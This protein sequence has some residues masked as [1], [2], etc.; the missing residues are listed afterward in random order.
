MR[1]WLVLLP[2]LL[3]GGC[4]LDL[5]NDFCGGD[6]C[7]CETDGDCGEGARCVN[8]F[9][10]T[11]GACGDETVTPPEECDN[12]AANGPSAPCTPACRLNRCGD[13]Y[14][15]TTSEPCDDGNDTN[16]DGCDTNCTLSACGNGVQAPGEACDDG[17]LTNGDGCDANCTLT[18][19]ASQ[20]GCFALDN[21]C[22]DGVC[23][24]TTG[25]CEV[26][27][28]NEGG[29]C[30]GGDLC[31][32]GGTCN[33]GAC[34]GAVATDCSSLSTDCV[35]GVCDPD[36][37]ACVAENVNDGGTC[38][39]GN[40]CTTGSTCLAGVCGGGVPATCDD[41]NACTSDS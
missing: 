14:Q 27:P 18:Q 38:D 34:V 15:L 6:P 19:C 10:D 24:P 8:N 23:N 35:Q 30:N 12:G 16:G 29:V 41:D 22:A 20:G 21:D 7:Q 31:Q 11:F 28:L 26:V 39:D 17:N 37:V 4:T 9:C 36:T 40:P 32:G 3:V 13:G 2:A 1:N 5:E 33:D 25:Q